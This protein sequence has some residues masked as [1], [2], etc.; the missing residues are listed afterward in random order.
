MY[1][2]YLWQSPHLCHLCVLLHFS[3]CPEPTDAGNTTG[4]GSGAVGPAV[5]ASVAVILLFVAIAMVITVVLIY[6][7]RRQKR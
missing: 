3:N 6:Y 5:G 2:Q 1:M 7:K 4:P